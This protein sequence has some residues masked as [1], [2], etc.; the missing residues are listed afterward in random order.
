MT[1]RRRALLAAL[2]VSALVLGIVMLVLADHTNHFSSPLA[3][4]G[5]F[6]LLGWSF[7]GAG[8]AALVRRPENRTGFLL[9]TVGIYWL[10]ASSL[11]FANSSVPFT[12]GA[13]LEAVVISPSTTLPAAVTVTVPLPAV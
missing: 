2:T 6:L 7:A 9:V 8:L 13:A 10:A 3:K 11:M 1:T 12:I 4:G 5:V